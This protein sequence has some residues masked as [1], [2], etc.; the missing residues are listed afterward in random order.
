MLPT[1]ITYIAS[2]LPVAVGFITF[3][4]KYIKNEKAKQ[5]L[6]KT[7]RIAELLQ[8]LVIEAEAFEHYSG[9]EKKQYVLTKANQYALSNRIRFVESEVSAMIDE[10][11]ATTRQVNRRPNDK[12]SATSDSK[13]ILI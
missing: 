9:E 11:I 12:I 2:V 6:Q 1:I 5:V 8:P 4:I 7:L 3:L 10:L 13:A